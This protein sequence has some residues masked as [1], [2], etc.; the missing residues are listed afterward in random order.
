MD[1]Q[2]DP[3]HCWWCGQALRPFDT[4]HRLWCPAERRVKDY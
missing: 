1:D 4:D 3:I 2:V